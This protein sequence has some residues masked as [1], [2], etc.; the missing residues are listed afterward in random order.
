[1]IHELAEA[2]TPLRIAVNVSPRQFAQADFTERVLTILGEK[3][4]DPTL[5]T[6]E[7]TEGLVIENIQDAAI[8]MSALS[9]HGVHFAIDDFGTGY[10]SLAYLKRL[11]LDELKIDKTFVLDAPRDPNDAAL[12]E[13]ILAVARHLGFSVV[14]EG[15]ETAAHLEFLK[16]LDCPAFQGYYFDRP[17]PWEEFCAR[18]PGNQRPGV[19][20]TASGP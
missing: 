11:P 14:A 5:L 16:A 19:G 3:R 10:S 8:K 12:V 20:V 13:T 7:V 15:V 1:M 4:A 17:L 9:H 6:L 18:W 2:G